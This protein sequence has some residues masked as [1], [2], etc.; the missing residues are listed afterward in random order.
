MEP[1]SRIAASV[2]DTAFPLLKAGWRLWPLAHVVTYGLIPVQ[3]RLLFVDAVELVWVV[4]LS[5]HCAS[6][7]RSG[8][9]V[10]EGSGGEAKITA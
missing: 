9:A 1:P 7:R 8:E 10:S 3:H 2:R 6:E 4:I 5:L